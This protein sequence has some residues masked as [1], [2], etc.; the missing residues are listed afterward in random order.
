[1]NR[2]DTMGTAGASSRNPPRTAPSRSATAAHAIVMAADCW[3]CPCLGRLLFMPRH[4]RAVKFLKRGDCRHV[5]DHGCKN[6]LTQNLQEMVAYSIPPS[7][8]AGIPCFGTSS[9]PGLAHRKAARWAPS[10]LAW[11]L[12]RGIPSI[13]HAR[14]QAPW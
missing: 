5:E 1:M 12:P 9:S 14:E 7:A 2:W 6:S 11:T 13:L 4:A 8:P 3:R 10:P